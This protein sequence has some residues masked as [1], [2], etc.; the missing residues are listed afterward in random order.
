MTN[1]LLKLLACA[2]LLWLSACT[3]AEE[4]CGEG[5]PRQAPH[6]YTYQTCPIAGRM[7]EFKL[8][9]PR[10]YQFMEVAYKGYDLWNAKTH[11]HNPKVPTLN[12]ELDYFGIRVRR[13]NFRPIE[14]HADILDQQK[15]SENERSTPLDQRWIW[16]SF[17]YQGKEGVALTPNSGPA[18]AYFG[19]PLTDWDKYSAPTYGRLIHNQ[20]KMWGLDHYLSANPPGTGSNQ[21]QQEYFLD[22]K[23][24]R[25]IRC[26][27][28]L[29]NVAPHV[30]LAWC[31]F[32]FKIVHPQSRDVIDVEVDLLLQYKADVS[33]WSHIEQ[34]IRT[35]FDSF[36]VR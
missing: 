15:F 14:T 35:V 20:K 18:T 13:N 10:Q 29:R 27:T 12:S 17:R 23:L 36:I 28:K 32:I 24:T 30:P 1:A 33:D 25:Q 6:P 22:G 34:G 26:E 19:S 5:V 8:A 21:S 4:P 7:G 9:I 3:Q 31:N 11:H 16:V 2:C